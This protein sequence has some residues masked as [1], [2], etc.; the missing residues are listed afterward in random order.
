M[1]DPNAAQ[2]WL[3]TSTP[4][5]AAGPVPVTAVPVRGNWREWRVR[6]VRPDGVEN[7]TA[8][9]GSRE[10]RCWMCNP[11]ELDALEPEKMAAIVFKYDRVRRYVYGRCPRCGAVG[12]WKAA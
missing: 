10:R 8:F 5:P 9:R 3:R 12:G 7:G 1:F 4:L 11:S 2:Q 6:L